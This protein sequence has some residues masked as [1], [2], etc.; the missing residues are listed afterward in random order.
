MITVIAEA[1]LM[2]CRHC[3]LAAKP[4]LEFCCAGCAEVYGLLI[5][6]GLGHFYQLQKEHSFRPPQ[7]V[8]NTP[9]YAKPSNEADEPN[10]KRFYLEGIHCLGCLWLLE[11]LPE[12]DKGIMEARLDMAHQI[13]EVK[14]KKG[15]T[16]WSEVLMWIA[17]LGY[18]AKPL[19]ED[20][21]FLESRRHDRISSLSRLGV[22]AFC[23]GNIILL[24][25]SIYSGSYAVWS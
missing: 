2:A 15:A 8:R 3:G 1:S 23:T 12:L 9:T 19:D 14:I 4:G 21:S 5:S 18:L 6:R 17:R 7:P 25:V 10:A 22:A 13:L 16:N 20:N 24:T 11:K